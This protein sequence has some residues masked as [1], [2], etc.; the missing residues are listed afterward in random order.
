MKNGVV[1]KKGKEKIFFD[2]HHWI[3]SG[4]IAS[5]PSDFVNGSIAPVLS[6]TNHLLGY[7]YFHRG[8]SLEGR[9]VSFGETSPYDAIRSSLHSAILLRKRL[10]D[11]TKTDA[12]RVVN[13]EADHLPGLIIDRYGEIFV[14][15][16]GTLGMEQL[17]LF[18][19]E[20]LVKLYPIKG[21]YEKSVNS[22]RKEEKLL[23]VQQ[24]LFGEIPDIFQIREEGLSFWI[25]IKS[26]QKTGFFLDQKQM[27]R[28]IG[29]LSH[30]KRVLNA[31]SYTGGFTVYALFYGATCVDSVEISKEACALGRQNIYLNGFSSE[32][33]PFLEEDVFSFLREKTYLPY[34]LV[35]LDPPAFA[36]K[37]GDVSQAIKGYREINTQA[38]AKMPNGSLLATFSC[39]YF[40][41]ETLFKRILIDSAKKAKRDI[42][43]VQSQRQ[44]FDHPYSPF[45]P[46]TSYLKGFL[47]YIT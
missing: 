6:C 30:E 31:F 45:H 20:E 34:D 44:S 23:P 19:I 18:I 27:R 22:S 3:F 40:I 37:R 4:A 43:I 24:P 21:I 13:S 1:L 25:Q 15:Q 26:G 39:S 17:K 46:E 35:I 7:A 33:A 10:I 29:E 8:L 5:Y 9:I 28:F 41:D 11:E 14:I 36:K 12:Y 16:I 2:R 32:R 47:L 38:M 42:V